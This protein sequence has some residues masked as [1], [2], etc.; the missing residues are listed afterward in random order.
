MRPN[1]HDKTGV[2]VAA[3]LLVSALICIGLGSVV[4]ALIYFV[5]R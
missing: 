3:I 1:E 2:L 5:N 4:L